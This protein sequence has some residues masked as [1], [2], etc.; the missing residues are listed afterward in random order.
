MMKRTV[1]KVVHASPDEN[2]SGTFHYITCL[3]VQSAIRVAK[4]MRE[5]R[6]TEYHIAVELH[7]EFKR[8]DEN[9][10]GWHAD[11]ESFPN[12]AIQHVDYY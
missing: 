2:Q 4:V 12:D 5:E 9:E 8:E 11:W 7:H 6:G 10:W 3:E 1:Y